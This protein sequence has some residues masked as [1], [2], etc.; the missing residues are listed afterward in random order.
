MP[1]ARPSVPSDA[2]LHILVVD[3]SA[4]VAAG[5]RQFL[6]A[7]KDVTEVITALDGRA[8]I[9]ACHQSRP[10]LVVMDVHMPEL[11][12]LKTTTRIRRE[13]PEMRIVLISVDQGADL[14]A[15]CLHSGADAFLPK[16]GLQ[17]NLMAEIDR[18]FP[19]RRKP[20]T[21]GGAGAPATRPDQTSS[22]DSSLTPQ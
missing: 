14:Q 18:L 3:D 20:G 21:R 11:D 6:S 13:Y 8:A 12:G 22:P 17:R 10:D 7:Q 15:D 1:E 9:E 19:G 2:G 5:I 4:T 16:I